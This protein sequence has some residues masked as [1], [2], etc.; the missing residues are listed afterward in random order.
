[1]TADWFV[2]QVAELAAAAEAADCFTA[3]LEAVEESGR[4][5]SKVGNS[6]LPPLTLDG[7]VPAI[8]ETYA[9][10][11]AAGW[12]DRAIAAELRSPGSGLSRALLAPWQF[13]TEA[14]YHA[15]VANGFGRRAATS[16]V[17]LRT[18]CVP[19]GKGDTEMAGAP[20]G[21]RSSVSSAFATRW[22]PL[23]TGRR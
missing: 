13:S 6:I 11:R 19:P 10:V 20:E 15:A 9:A 17:G 18:A 21:H 22:A 2:M 4:R 23:T 5:A 14:D 3:L 7:F 12:T 16:T 8:V 1:M